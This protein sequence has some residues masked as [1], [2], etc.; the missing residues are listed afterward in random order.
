MAS[1]RP[2][3]SLLL[4]MVGGSSSSDEAVCIDWISYSDVQEEKLD[5]PRVWYRRVETV[6]PSNVTGRGI[7]K[8]GP[9]G[10]IHGS[11]INSPTSYPFSFEFCGSTLPQSLSPP[12]LYLIFPNFLQKHTLHSCRSMTQF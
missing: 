9:I 4:C 2:R 1:F 8:S 6:F 12:R 10:R 11:Y 3:R 5:H 7:D